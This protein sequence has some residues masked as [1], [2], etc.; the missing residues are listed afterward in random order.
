M[1]SEI[2]AE[3][4]GVS[5]SF[6]KKSILSDT[7]LSIKTGQITCLA[8][9]S[10]SGKSTILYIL[11]GFLKPNE[12]K[13]FF[14]NKS[15]YTFGEFGLGKYRKQ[16]IGFLFQDFR[17][18]PFLTVEENIRFPAY[19]SGQKTDEAHVKNLLSRLGI[20]HRRKAYPSEISGGEAQRTAL[21]R[22]LYMKPALLLLDEPTGNLDAE[23]EK[24]IFQILKDLRNEGLALVCVTHSKFILQNADQS[25]RL[26]GGKLLEYGHQAVAVAAEPISSAPEKI[27]KKR[28][29]A[30]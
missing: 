6:G 22:A 20:E 7:S 21:G 29:T 24:E 19:F 4:S 3:L 12:G 11:G 2:L 13:L 10:G 25:Y 18:L 14:R 27:T 1:N 16:N 8:G 15:V 5:F 23:T 9:P 28:K 30:K 17:L 26:S